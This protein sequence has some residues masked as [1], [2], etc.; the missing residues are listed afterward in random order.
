MPEVGATCV[1]AVSG[2]SEPAFVVTYF[3]L[4]QSD[5]KSF[6]GDREVLVPGDISLTTSDRNGVLIRSGGV[7]D[8]QATPAAKTL[9]LPIGNRITSFCQSYIVETF[10][11]S[12]RWETNRPEE[13]PNGNTGTCLTISSKEFAD[14]PSPVV[15]FKAGA[16]IDS[17]SLSV[18]SPVLQYVVNGSGSTAA[19]TEVSAISANKSGEMTVGSTSK[20]LLLVPNATFSSTAKKVIVASKS[21]SATE[22]VILG[23][24]FITDLS[25]SLTELQAAVNA[26]GILTP[27]T[28]SLLTKIA[29]SI[30]TGSPYLSSTLESE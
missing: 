13:D 9:W 3:P 16:D 17:S 4:S 29:T 28:L 27:N 23:S 11:G 8:I 18:K 21:S 22:P 7:V 25:S 14:E 1:V 30:S 20:L 24:T 10:G 5:A 2:K 6:T 15:E 19:P 12:L 26:L